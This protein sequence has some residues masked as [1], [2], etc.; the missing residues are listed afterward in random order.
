MIPPLVLDTM[1]G[2]GLLAAG[3]GL[4]KVAQTWRAATR[5]VNVVRSAPP[6]AVRELPPIP[7]L[8]T[9]A[10]AEDEEDHDDSPP[11]VVPEAV[12]IDMDEFEKLVRSSNVS[13]I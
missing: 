11:F 7:Y 12:V 10:P 3:Y 9:E 2:L 8:A 4:V 1:F 5:I 6:A 13:R